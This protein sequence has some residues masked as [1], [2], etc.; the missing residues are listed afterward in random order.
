MCCSLYSFSLCF[1]VGLPKLTSKTTHQG[2]KENPTLRTTTHKHPRITVKL[3]SL[4]AHHLTELSPIRFLAF[5]LQQRKG[6]STIARS[7]CHANFI[8]ISRR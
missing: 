8:S 7:F 3:L 4:R 1:E 5:I 2:I 6:I